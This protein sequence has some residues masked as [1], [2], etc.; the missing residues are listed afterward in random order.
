MIVP[1]RSVATMCSVREA[2]TGYNTKFQ[3]SL[4]VSAAERGSW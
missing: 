4:F 3:L 2:N 1:S